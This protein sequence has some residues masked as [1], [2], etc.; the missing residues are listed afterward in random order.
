[1]SYA[2]LKR[3]VEQIKVAAEYRFNPI[4]NTEVLIQID[5]EEFTYKNLNEGIQKLI[6][7]SRCIK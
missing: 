6:D 7:F 5:G 4:E 3:E 1:M 2:S